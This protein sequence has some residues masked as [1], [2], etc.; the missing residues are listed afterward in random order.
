M[1]VSSWCS[2]TDK[3][4]TKRAANAWE[5]RAD[6]ALWLHAGCFIAPLTFQLY[7]HSFNI[8]N[9]TSEYKAPFANIYRGMAVIG[10]QVGA[11]AGLKFLAD[12]SR[13]LKNFPKSAVGALV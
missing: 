2:V 8:G 12:G 9:P 4:C 13:E 10:T 1:T 5:G 3:S 7:W 11:T 6:R